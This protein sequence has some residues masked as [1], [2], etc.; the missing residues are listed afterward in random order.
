MSP[1]FKGCPVL[2]RLFGNGLAYMVK[3]CWTK[4]LPCIRYAVYSINLSVSK[5]INVLP[6]QHL[7]QQTVGQSL[8]SWTAVT[9]TTFGGQSPSTSADRSKNRSR[10]LTLRV[11]W[12]GEGGKRS[13]NW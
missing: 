5:N 12:L 8:D 13:Y 1:L 4:P 7:Q 10:H 3:I 6:S 9:T 11:R 2:A